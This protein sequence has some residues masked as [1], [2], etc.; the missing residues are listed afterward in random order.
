MFLLR[1]ELSVKIVITEKNKNLKEDLTGGMALRLKDC[2]FIFCQS[3]E[4]ILRNIVNADVLIT[5]SRG[6]S[7]S[8]L[9]TARNLKLV[10]YI[11]TGYD[12]ADLEACREAGVKVANVP[13]RGSGNAESVAETAIMHM[14]LLAK[15]QHL[16]QKSFEDRTI[17]SPL[18]TALW[19]KK[20]LV[21]G[22]GNLGHTIAERLMGLGMEVQGANRTLRPDFC[23]WGLSEVFPLGELTDAVKGCRFVIIALPSNSHTENL[24]NRDVMKAMDRNSWLINVARPKIVNRED[25]M[26]ALDK[27]WIAGAGLD[28]IWN[29][30]ADPDDPLF[31][32]P[33]LSLSPHVGA[34]TDEFFK[35]VFA[36][37]EEN[38]VRLRDGKSI[39]SVVN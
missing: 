13:S 27:K 25:F 7:R 4:E 26:E 38:L 11:G 8:D 39:L 12:S 18:G 15:R 9:K 16:F 2:D 20:A 19:K 1:R 35:G 10:Q 3:E 31:K 17:Y 36:H 32:D 34:G 29:E 21:I 23:S 6:I 14:L 30:P 22:L 5:S 37:I 24:I 28:V 33:R